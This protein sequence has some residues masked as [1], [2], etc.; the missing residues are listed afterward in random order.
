VTIFIGGDDDLPE[1]E[2]TTDPSDPNGVAGIPTATSTTR[3]PA[4]DT[5]IR[6]RR[7]NVAREA[8]RRRLWW[9]LIIGGVVAVAL[10]VLGLL[11]SRLFGVRTVDITGTRYTTQA[12]L[13]PIVDSIKGDPILTL[14]LDAVRHRLESLPYVER[15]AVATKF[16]HTVRVDI[17]ERQPA[18]AYAGDDGK[19]RVI[20]D[21]GRVI[22]VID[23]QPADY[24]AISGTGGDLLAG[25]RTP[26]AFAAAA[27]LARWAPDEIR[28]LIDSFTVSEGGDLTMNLKGGTQVVFGDPTSKMT[29]K[30][31]VMLTVL[32][33]YDLA[34]LGSVNVSDYSNPGILGR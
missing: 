16:P 17:V 24:P 8:S 31:T 21:T 12:Q 6:R 5:K 32:H 22:A 10:V 4:M 25:Q 7:I 26:A 19:W 3:R 29:E 14:D 30:L 33:K 27:D 20:D 15:A 23:G 28:K 13:K 18:A 11:T 34:K 9:I 1:P 2:T